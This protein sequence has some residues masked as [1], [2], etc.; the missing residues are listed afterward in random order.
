LDEILKSVE[1]S[2]FCQEYD[3]VTDTFHAESRKSLYTSFYGRMNSTKSP[4]S[5]AGKVRESMLMSHVGRMGK[6]VCTYE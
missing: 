5:S 1:Q 3:K 6:F 4:V 2:Q